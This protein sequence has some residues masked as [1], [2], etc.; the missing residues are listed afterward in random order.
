MP[1][2]FDRITRSKVS[3]RRKGPYSKTF[4][5]MGSY[6]NGRC[7]PHSFEPL[8]G[9]TGLN[10]LFD[11]RHPRIVITPR[12]SPLRSL[13]TQHLSSH[14][15]IGTKKRASSS[16]KPTIVCMHTRVRPPAGPD[17][18]AI[19]DGNVFF[20]TDNPLQIAVLNLFSTLKSRFPHFVVAMITRESVKQAFANGIRAEQIVSYL[21]VH[22]HPQ[23]RR[24]VRVSMHRCGRDPKC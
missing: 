15:T 21:T 7:L 18:H 17:V 14:P 16:W 19:E 3:P 8:V 1:F 13:R 20:S 2:F 6:T 4:A 11:S 23:M 9:N 5:I 12:V 10:D 24:Q 22:A